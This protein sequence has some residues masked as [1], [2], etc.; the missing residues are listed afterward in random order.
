MAR[1]PLAGGAY[2][3][4]S[5]IAAAQ[6]QVNLYSEP[7]PAGQGEPSN[8]AL[9]PMPGTRVLTTMEQGPI[10]SGHLATNGNV[11]VCAGAGIYSLDANWTATPLGSITPGL[12]TPVSM[13]DN[14]QTLVIVDGSA[15]GW[16]VDLAT[17]AFAQIADP[18]GLFT[19]G[20]R[21]DYLDT[22]LLFNQPNT[23]RFYWSLSGNPVTFDPLA[24]D[25][26][27]KS[28]APDLLVTLVV[29]KRQ[30]WLL[31][32]DTS[33]VFYDI[34]A[35]GGASDSQFAAIPGIMIDYGCAAKY[36]AA[37]INNSVYWLARDRRGQG[38][39]VEGAG[40]QTKRI[41]TYAIEAEL[42]TYARLDDAIG[43]SFHIG[44]H[45]FYCLAFPHADKCWAYDVSA[46]AAANEPRWTEWVWI[47]SNG[48]EHR[49][50]S[51]CAFFARGL[52]VV[53]DW[54]DG[55]LYA[56]DSGVF[57]D[58][59][60]P[61]KRLRRFPH[62]LA[63]GKRV[64]YR[65]FVADLEGG[66]GGADLPEPPQVSLRWSDDRGHTFGSPVLIDGGGTGEYLRTLQWQRL[67]MARDRV[68]E[69]SWSTPWPVALQGAWLEAVP[70][71]S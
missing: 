17:N 33:E 66:T 47:D 4:R 63:D 70:A 32:R 71:S 49:H 57:T 16:T 68:F 35:P 62:L 29:A 1:I 13:R 65:Q 20:D 36:S 50:R 34:G 45:L 40:L 30:I 26:A 27:L 69:I 44:G 60:A 3:A 18:G 31:G 56:L 67:G 25:F 52:V 11:Y 41:S 64:I 5:V 51:N 28:S 38:I 6:R 19:G 59:G 61:I 10:R 37:E 2:T 8:A 7:M 22:F 46:S 23:P 42:A 14:S 21:V 9:Y 55:R 39:V 54:Q 15:N 24:L 58:D 48:T 12:T 43:F 53:G